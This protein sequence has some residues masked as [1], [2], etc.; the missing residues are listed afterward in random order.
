MDIDEAGFREIKV[1]GIGAIIGDGEVLGSLMFYIKEKKS[2]GGG[3][4]RVQWL[5]D[6]HTSSFADWR[7]ENLVHTI[8]A[9]YIARG[10]EFIIVLEEYKQLLKLPNCYTLEEKETKKLIAL[11]DWKRQL[12]SYL[13]GRIS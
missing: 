13:D 8:N 9:S 11:Q 4:Y 2:I 3:R 7:K 6:I 10:T 1:S 5:W 12:T